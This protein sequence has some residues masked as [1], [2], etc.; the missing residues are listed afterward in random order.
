MRDI[1][2][3]QAPQLTT[4]P[5]LIANTPP[6]LDSCLPSQLIILL[7]MEDTN[8]RRC[9]FSLRHSPCIHSP[10]HSHAQPSISTP[11]ASH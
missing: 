9:L 7:A 8:I 5:A 10:Y 3:K 1:N 11:G 4:L 6:S 2:S